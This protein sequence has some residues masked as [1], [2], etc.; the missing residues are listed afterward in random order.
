VL[1]GAFTGQRPLAKVAR[2]WGSSKKLSRWEN[3]RGYLARARQNRMQHYCHWHLQ[4]VE[5]MLAVVTDDETTSAFLSHCPFS[6]DLG[7]TKSARCTGTFVLSTEIW[8][9]LRTNGWHTTMGPANKNY[10]LNTAFQGS[11]G[12][13]TNIRCLS[14]FLMRIFVFRKLH[15]FEFGFC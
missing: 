14:T 3:R 5:A 6:S 1:F 4:V 15:L 10:I 9:I 7:T 12:G 11:I 2:P 13:F 8:G